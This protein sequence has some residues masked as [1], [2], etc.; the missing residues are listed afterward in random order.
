MLCRAATLGMLLTTGPSTPDAATFPL[1]EAS[2]ADP[3]AAGGFDVLVAGDHLCGAGSPGAVLLSA[4]SSS[5]LVLQGPTPHVVAQAAVPDSSDNRPPW[6]AGVAIGPRV[7][8]LRPAPRSGTN[9]GNLVVLTIDPGC[10]AIA[11]VQW[12]TVHRTGDWA[13]LAIPSGSG[14]SGNGG[15]RG[16]SRSAGLPPLHA[17]VLS[18]LTPLGAAPQLVSINLQV[19][20][21]VLATSKTISTIDRGPDCVFKGLAPTARGTLVAAAHCRT[22]TANVFELEPTG[23]ILNSTHV[24]IGGDSNWAGVAVLDVA[25]DGREQILL[26]RR[27]GVQDGGERTAIVGWDS[28]DGSLLAVNPHGGEVEGPSGRPGVEMDGTMQVWRHIAVGNWLGDADQQMLALRAYNESLSGTQLPVNLLVYGSAMHVLPRRFAVA[29]TLV[30]P[31]HRSVGIDHILT[32]KGRLRVQGQQ[33]VPAASLQTGVGVNSTWL[34]TLL[35]HT[36]SN[37]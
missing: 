12:A 22:G 16:S 26:P 23:T 35:A 10:T 5:A 3:F 30:R 24:S 31:T 36:H 7:L 33:E 15:V 11:S 6:H 37:T 20:D 14:G 27:G 32:T 21:S 1:I 9:A 19:G 25:G 29:D 2:G 4:N 17:V 28:T 13:G 8:A 34:K 18:I